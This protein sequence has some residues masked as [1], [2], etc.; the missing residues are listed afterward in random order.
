MCNVHYNLQTHLQYTVD[1][2]A[3][4]P[5]ASGSIAPYSS[6]LEG[7][8]ISFQCDQGFS[9]P[10]ERTATC[11]RDEDTGSAVWDPNPGEHTCSKNETGMLQ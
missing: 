2:G 5:P 11:A 4:Q 3:P 9:P 7:A 1:C 6:T 10:E 8:G